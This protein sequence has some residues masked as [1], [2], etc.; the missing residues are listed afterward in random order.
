[1]KNVSNIYIDKKDKL[2]IGAQNRLFSYLIKEDKYILWDESDGF[3]LNELLFMYQ[4]ESESPYIYLG[5]TAGLV[6]IDKEA[7]APIVLLPNIQLVDI[8]LNGGKALDQFKSQTR[9]IVIPSNYTSLSITFGLG[10]I[11]VFEKTIFRYE[12]IGDDGTQ[13]TEDYYHSY[14]P[15]FLSPGKYLLRVSYNTKDGMWTPPSPILSIVVEGPWYTKGWAILLMVA[16]VLVL[17][18][19]IMIW[20]NRREKRKLK[21]QLKIKE[22]QVREDKLNFFVN[23]SHEL[24]TPL[25]LIYAPLSRILHNEILDRDLRTK[26]Q[27]IHQQTQRMSNIIN[28][29]I[30]FEK[31]ENNID[32]LNLEIHDLNQFIEENA[33]SFVTEFEINGIDLTLDLTPNIPAILFDEKKCAIVLSSLLANAYK[34]SDKG[35]TISIT[36]QVLNSYV[37]ISVL[38]EGIRGID[39]DNLFERFYQG[40]HQL[41]GTGIGLSYAKEIIDNHLGT[42]G[43]QEKEKGAIF[44]FDLPLHATLSDYNNADFEINNKIDINY[45]NLLSKMDTKQ[46]NLLIVEDNKDL[47]DF[48]HNSL[49]YMFNTIFIANDGIEALDRLKKENIDIIISDVMMPRMNGYE[50]CKHVKSDIN[51]NHIPVILLTARDDMESKKHGYIAGAD[52][53]ISKPFDIDTLLLRVKNLLKNKEGIIKKFKSSSGLSSIAD[54]TENKE[55]EEFIKKMNQYIFDNISQPTLEVNDLVKALSL[56]RA[57]LYAKVKALTNQGVKDYINTLRIE[58]AKLLLAKSTTRITDISIEVGFTSQRYFSSVFKENVGITPSEFRDRSR[59]E[60]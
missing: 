59:E 14:Y 26:L 11:N 10:L 60:V 21:A 28:M 49:A 38:D 55:D 20:Y 2:W 6:V 48:I 52:S 51:S 7:P 37:R 5:G 22:Q 46:Y 25:S 17:L 23:I 19:T 35:T 34:F 24:K 9:E 3:A 54:I 40:T 30:N 1:M 45:L 41:G 58:R 16:L 4:K 47:L 29:T 57:S 31:K 36:S 32:K 53:Y 12:L 50:L 56:S 15:P 39:K 42:I 43:A 13:I 44:Y 8:T 27:K 33:K 18:T